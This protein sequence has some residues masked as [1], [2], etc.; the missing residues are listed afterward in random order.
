[1]PVLWVNGQFSGQPST[2]II[3]ANTSHPTGL[4]KIAV[5]SHC[6]PPPFW[7]LVKFGCNF[8]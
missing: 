5:N 2:S 3:I 6:D 8:M 1:M 4:T 7:G